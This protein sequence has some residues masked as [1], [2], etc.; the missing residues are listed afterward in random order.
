[1]NVKEKKRKLV[2]DL[3]VRLRE[4]ICYKY[5]I[6]N[7]TKLKSREEEL[8][9]IGEYL[10]NLLRSFI[11]ND[12][13]TRME[14]LGVWD[15]IVKKILKT[16]HYSREEDIVEFIDWIDTH[17]EFEDLINR[18]EVKELYDEIEKLEK[19]KMQTI[20]ALT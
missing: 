11:S 8:F 1:M 7:I 20:N 9:S 10:P 15:E 13:Y 17:K 16:K 2:E 19:Q 4:K 14:E 18:D 5:M 12:Y 3:Y 6:V